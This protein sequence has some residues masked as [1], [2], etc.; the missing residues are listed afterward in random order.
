VWAH[1][2]SIGRRRWY[3][4]WF[5]LACVIIF[6]ATPVHKLTMREVKGHCEPQYVV[7]LE[8]IL[9][10]NKAGD[11]YGFFVSEYSVNFVKVKAESCLF[12]FFVGEDGRRNN[13]RRNISASDLS[14]IIRLTYRSMLCSGYSIVNSSYNGWRSPVVVK[15][16][17]NVVLFH[18]KRPGAM[19]NP[20][21]GFSD[22][23]GHEWSF[24]FSESPLCSFGRGFSRYYNSFGV[25]KLFESCTDEAAGYERERAMVAAKSPAV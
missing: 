7:I 9:V 14:R 12:C 10:S 3:I 1:G 23:D 22:F 8:K 4:R 21:S 2:L 17:D 15:R 13:T 11:P 24:K 25:S 19:S 16:Y 20:E 5:F 6:Y 18:L